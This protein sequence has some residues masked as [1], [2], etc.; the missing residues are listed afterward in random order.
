LKD[1]LLFAVWF[2][3][4]FHSTDIFVPELQIRTQLWF[5]R[6]Y[7]IDPDVRGFI[8]HGLILRTVELT[9]YHHR[10]FRKL[11]VFR[12]IATVLAPRNIAFVEN[13]DSKSRLPTRSPK[14]KLKRDISTRRI[15][16]KTTYF[17]RAW[18]I[19]N[20]E[21][22]V[23]TRPTQDRRCNCNLVY[24]CKTRLY[25]IFTVQ[26]ILIKISQKWHK[27][28]FASHQKNKFHFIVCL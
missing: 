28:T 2:F 7:L 17:T 16:S 18:W 3:V 26:R 13:C 6:S 11:R 22:S 9:K 4:F 21:V 14:T 25:K 8:D 12:N 5:N 1:Y 24:P 10:R 19:L 15:N 27:H 23:K 20:Y